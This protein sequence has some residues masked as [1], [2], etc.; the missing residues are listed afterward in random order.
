M[1][2]PALLLTPDLYFTLIGVLESCALFSTS[3]LLFRVFTIGISSGYIGLA[4]WVG[5]A[6]PGMT[7][8]LTIACLD[9]AI[10]FFM[11]ASFFY[12]RSILSL[13]PGWREVYRAHFSTLL[14]FEFRR[15]LRLGTVVVLERSQP[16]LIVRAGD[17]FK[18]LYF[19]LEGSADIVLN[20]TAHATLQ[21]GDWIA[22]FSM[23]TGNPASADVRGSSLRLLS[24]DAEA[25][26]KLKASMPDVSEK[27]NALIARNLC[28]K[29]VRANGNAHQVMA[30]QQA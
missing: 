27:I 4:L 22:E 29:L 19:L 14:P 16:E 18:Q 9:V 20:G 3:L 8:I 15:L 25:M 26:R 6:S 5:L 23:I 1:A 2:P 12:A 28:D 24:W 11:V 21:D 30:E 7:S 13:Q 17:A 10:N